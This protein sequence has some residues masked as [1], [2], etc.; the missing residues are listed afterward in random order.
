MPKS[1]TILGIRLGFPFILL[2]YVYFDGRKI[3]P[4]RFQHYLPLSL[5]VGGRWCR[6][7][8]LLGVAGSITDSRTRFSRRR[9]GTDLGATGY[10]GTEGPATYSASRDRHGL[11]PDTRCFSHWDATAVAN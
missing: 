11:E 3:P 1:S 4:S 6:L 7:K 5:P 2:I 8:T 10:D 9:M